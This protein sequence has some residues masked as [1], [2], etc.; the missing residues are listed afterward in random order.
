MLLVVTSLSLVLETPGRIPRGND[1]IGPEGHEPTWYFIPYIF[2]CSFFL[3]TP[4]K[5]QAQR[6][7]HSVFS[8][9]SMDPL[10]N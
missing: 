3:D 5:S 7:Y 6:T 9:K 10:K 8:I 2:F 4:T 1:S